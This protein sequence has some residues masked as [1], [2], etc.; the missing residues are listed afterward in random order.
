MN[1]SSTIFGKISIFLIFITLMLTSAGP[2]LA[3]EEPIGKVAVFSGEVIL[4]GQDV[5]GGDV[6]VGLPIFSGDKIVTLDGSAELVFEDGTNVTLCR[7]SAVEFK[8]WTRKGLP[9]IQ[10]DKTR[11]RFTLYAGKMWIETDY[12]QMRSEIAVPPMVSGLRE[13]AGTTRIAAL[14]SLDKNGEAF[15]SFDE[16]DRSFTIGPWKM[17]VAEN[18]PPAAAKEN[19]FIKKALAAK[20]AALVAQRASEK[21]D[22]DKAAAESL[23]KLAWIRANKA[24]AEEAL[25]SAKYLVDWTPDKQVLGDSREAARVAEERLK[26][27]EVAEKAAIEA[28]ALVEEWDALYQTAMDEFEDQ[29]AIEGVD[30]GSIGDLEGGGSRSVKP[31]DLG[32]PKPGAF[33]SKSPCE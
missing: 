29:R 31:N 1:K 24:S 4:R 2:S 13:D 18:V 9:L 27:A 30:E 26:T 11:R 19:E 32:M 21:E 15:M 8:Q 23:R 14:I 17:G 7:Y 6:V 3:G 16:G 10:S 22:L 20:T 28:G 33:T 25:Y 5:W 12:R